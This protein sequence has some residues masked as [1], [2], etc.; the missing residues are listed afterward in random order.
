MMSKQNKPNSTEDVL[1][2]MK[3]YCQKKGYKF[4]DNQLAY[5]AESCYLLY[6]SRGWKGITYWPAVA[7]K[8]VLT[9]IHNQQKGKVDIKKTQSKS[10]REIIMEQEDEF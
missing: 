4:S 5:M 3:K 9:N 6:E 8:W 1:Q 10:V 7:M 2:E